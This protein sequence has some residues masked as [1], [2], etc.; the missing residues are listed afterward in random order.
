ILGHVQQDG[1]SELYRSGDILLFPSLLDPHPLV[2]L[3][4][5]LSG[6]FVLGT[7]RS[8]AT[9]DYIRSGLNGELFSPTDTAG[10]A[11]SIRKALTGLPYDRRGIRATVESVTPAGEAEKL[12]RA[13]ELALRHAKERNGNH[14]VI[15]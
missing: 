10:F 3:E 12:M 2:V 8:A 7:D 6:L 11:E 9:R 14:T 1:L 13:T 15:V 4:A 5:L